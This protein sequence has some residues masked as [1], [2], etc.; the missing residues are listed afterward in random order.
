M[1]RLADVET[2]SEGVVNLQRYMVKRLFSFLKHMLCVGS[3]RC[4][5]PN[6]HKQ[7]C[8][9]FVQRRPNVFDAG[10]TLYKWYSYILC[11]L[12]R[13]DMYLASM[14]M[15]ICYSK[16]SFV[17]FVRIEEHLVCLHAAR[18]YRISAAATDV[19]NDASCGCQHGS[20]SA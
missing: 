7:N 8:I 10:P 16:R 2:V 11:L 13:S 19:S 4:Q 18:H 15:A 5:V 1:C 3:R 6:K 12:C 17:L 20:V 14:S 9:T